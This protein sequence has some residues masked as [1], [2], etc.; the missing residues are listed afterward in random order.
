MKL[1]EMD[2][3]GIVLEYAFYFHGGADGYSKC[4]VYCV[5]HGSMTKEAGLNAF[6]TGV[7]KWGIPSR[8]RSDCGTEN[9]GWWKFM[10]I[11]KGVPGSDGL[12]TRGTVLTG[13]RYY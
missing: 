4:M 10:W 9:F 11:N 2:F 12:D 8:C 5:V 3:Y 1:F 6:M 7:N 13:P